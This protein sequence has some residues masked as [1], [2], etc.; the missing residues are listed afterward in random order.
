M[1]LVELS[2]L[3]VTI[4]N[5]IESSNSS[6]IGL[7]VCLIAVNIAIIQ[8]FKR[9]K[10]G[11]RTMKRVPKKWKPAI[12]VFVGLFSSLLIVATLDLS[13]TRALM[14]IFSGPMSG[15]IFDF[16]R[17]FKEEKHTKQPE[18]NVFTNFDSQFRDVV[19]ELNKMIREYQE[20]KKQSNKQENK[21]DENT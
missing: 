2:H 11:K 6:T 10:I 19:M 3:F 20:T 17:G 5:Q 12:P 16:A 15:F 9:S 18:T 13:I 14:L 7:L 8:F 1:E 4:S 21:E